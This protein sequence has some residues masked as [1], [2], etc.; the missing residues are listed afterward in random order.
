MPFREIKLSSVAKLHVNIYVAAPMTTF[1]I[2]G[3]RQGIGV[4][5]PSRAISISVIPTWNEKQRLKRGWNSERAGKKKGRKAELAGE[6]KKTT[7][8][9]TAG[10]NIVDRRA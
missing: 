10:S 8:G 9:E 6:K 1:Q 5:K 2:S 4:S 7:S 3:Y